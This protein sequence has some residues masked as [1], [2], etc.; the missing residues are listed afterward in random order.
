[1]R[2][3]GAVRCGVILAVCT[4][5]GQTEMA[6]AGDLPPS[7][8]EIPAHPTNDAFYCLSANPSC[9]RDPWWMEWTE[10]T[11]DQIVSFAGMG[12]GLVA[13]SRFAEA[14]NLIRQWDDGSQLLT[15]AE[16][17]GLTIRTGTFSK[18][19]TAIAAYNSSRHE[20]VFSPDYA[21]SPTWMVAAVLT[22]ELRH[23]ADAGAHA[24]QA[25]TPDDCFARELR[26]YEQEARFMTWFSADLVKQPIPDAQLRESQSSVSRTLVALL[27]RI[28]N[29][30]DLAQMVH[31]DYRVNCISFP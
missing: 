12:V 20:I 8:F 6:R 31:R 2:T 4:L 14:V 30:P 17:F 5:L 1:M 3:F 27:S 15:E 13:E 26:G 7:V 25:H 11:E 9:A 19:P 28:G 10:P 21:T 22:H 18:D 16:T 24:F 23:I 29:A